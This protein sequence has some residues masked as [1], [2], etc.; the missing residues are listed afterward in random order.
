[1]ARRAHAGKPT[2]YRWWPDRTRLL[3]AVYSEF[4]D[5]MRPFDTGS[6]EG[7][8]RAFITNLLA[9]WRESPA[10]PVF[11]SIL[12]ESQTDAAASAAFAEYHYGRSARNAAAFAKHGIAPEDAAVLTELAVN[13]GWGQLLADR[14]DPGDEEIARVARML[15]RGVKAT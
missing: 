8:V 11:R 12:S 13:Y 10:G 7:D 1:V 4:K 15:V 6:L 5:Q 9:F 2:I 14:L 3:L